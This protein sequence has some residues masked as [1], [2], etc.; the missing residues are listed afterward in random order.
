ME[1]QRNFV[2]GSKILDRVYTT[3]GRITWKKSQNT[4]KRRGKRSSEY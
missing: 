2:E 3:I 4:R 1:H